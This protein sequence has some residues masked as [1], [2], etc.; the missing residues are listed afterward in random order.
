MLEISLEYILTS[1]EIHCCPV[2]A[3][4]SGDAKTPSLP[5]ELSKYMKWPQPGTTK[6]NK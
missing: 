4:K 6:L 5:R 1:N 2:G 3:R